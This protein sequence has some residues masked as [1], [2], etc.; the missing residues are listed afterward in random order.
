MNRP[1]CKEC[2]QKHV[3]VNY[4][5][6]GKTYYRSK[7]DSCLRLAKKKKPPKPNW[8]KSGYQ[9]KMVCDKCGFKARWADQIIVFYADGDLKNT[10]KNNLKSICLNCT[11]E[12]D[13]QDIPWAKDL[14]PRADVKVR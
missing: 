3:A 4:I 7:C 5:R 8:S 6:N 9:K 10:K 13:K 2:N 12:L 1:L 11:I 14:S